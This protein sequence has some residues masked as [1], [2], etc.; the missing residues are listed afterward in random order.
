MALGKCDVGKWDI[1]FEDR[2]QGKEYMEGEWT[3]YW[4]IQLLKIK[5][6]HFIWDFMQKKQPPSDKRH[7][8]LQA[9]D[10]MALGKCNVGKWDI[11]F[12]DRWQGKE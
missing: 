12:E 7:K 3:N 5:I 9:T 11:P 8:S 4:N 2:W 6:L 10:T 1:P